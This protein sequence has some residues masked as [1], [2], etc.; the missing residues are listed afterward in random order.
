M[1][2]VC[3]TEMGQNEKSVDEHS[4]ENAVVICEVTSGKM[5][6]V[7]EST[8]GIGLFPR[9]CPILSRPITFLLSHTNGTRSVLT[10][11]RRGRR[12]VTIAPGGNDEKMKG[13]LDGTDDDELK[14]DEDETADGFLRSGDNASAGGQMMI[15]TVQRPDDNNMDEIKTTWA[16][17]T[18]TTCEHR[19]STNVWDERQNLLVGSR[20]EGSF[21]SSKQFRTND[22]REWLGSRREVG[23]RD[24]KSA[25]FHNLI[26]R[27]KKLSWF[28]EN[29]VDRG[30]AA[31][32]GEVPKQCWRPPDAMGESENWTVPQQDYRHL[33]DRW[34]RQEER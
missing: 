16:E 6:E 15:A 1:E 11:V 19:K 26:D 17:M 5:I 32:K 25:Y 18:E 7:G 23:P 8:R 9:F 29:E 20:S 28:C 21:R 13:S 14:F 31:S 22:D 10:M 12:E 33:V 3:P 4:E 34:K 27:W 30:S 24:V 2:R